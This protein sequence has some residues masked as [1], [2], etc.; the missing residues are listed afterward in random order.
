MFYYIINLIISHFLLSL[1]KNRIIIEFSINL[2][3]ED[4][5]RTANTV[6]LCWS[7]VNNL[8]QMYENHFY[9]KFKSQ[10]SIIS[11]RF[12]TTFMSLSNDFTQILLLISIYHYSSVIWPY[13]KLYI[14]NLLG[15]SYILE[16]SNGRHI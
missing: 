3:K 5:Y 4:R 14:C 6:N 2:T 16:K 13:L 8:K 9:H 7:E 11:Y 10:Q 12:L 1:V 15:S